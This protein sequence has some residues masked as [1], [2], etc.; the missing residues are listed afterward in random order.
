MSQLSRYDPP[1]A[2]GRRCG[3]HD[4]LPRV[5]DR[6]GSRVHA[7]DVVLRSD[8]IAEAFAPAV[9]M[10]IPTELSEK[11]KADGRPLIARLKQLAAGAR[12]VSIQR[13]SARRATLTAAVGTGGLVLAGML[14]DSVRAGLT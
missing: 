1:V 8:E 2:P 6:R 14:V 10:P 3:Q 9:G 5:T 13:W 12:P 4:A 7:S 11:M